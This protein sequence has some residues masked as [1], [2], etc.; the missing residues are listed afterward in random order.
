[1]PITHRVLVK[2][3]EKIQTKIR[4]D[5]V[6][7]WFSVFG[8]HFGFL[9]VIEDIEHVEEAPVPHSGLNH[10]GGAELPLPVA[11]AAAGCSVLL[12]SLLLV[13]GGHQDG[14]GVVAL[15]DSSAAPGSL[16]GVAV[17]VLGDVLVVL[18]LGPGG[19]WDLP[20]LVE[21]APVVSS[22]APVLHNFL[23]YRVLLRVFSGY[24]EFGLFY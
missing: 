19:H 7:W 17:V 10:L 15:G 9:L 6:C 2:N 23:Q 3:V 8:F 1:M 24:F 14:A 16:A 5:V 4:L 13:S 22:Q 11:G 12:G 20:E 21:P 18:L